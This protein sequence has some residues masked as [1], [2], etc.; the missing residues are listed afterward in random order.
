[1]SKSSISKDQECSLSIFHLTIPLSMS[2]ESFPRALLYPRS[3]LSL[4]RGRATL[5]RD[6]RDIETGIVRWNIDTPRSWSLEKP[7]LYVAE[8]A[9]QYDGRRWT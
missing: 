9:E 2:R 4:E 5:G 8:N 6:S 1:M 3:Y 7:D